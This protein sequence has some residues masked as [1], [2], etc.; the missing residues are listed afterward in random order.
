MGDYF[1]KLFKIKNLINRYHKAMYGERYIT[2]LE[3][4][5]MA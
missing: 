4:I 2:S 5:I 3:K 1:E